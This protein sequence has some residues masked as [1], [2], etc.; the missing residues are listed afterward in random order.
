MQKKYKAYLI[1]LD[2]TIYRG[3]Q[4]IEGASDFISSLNQ[5]KI[6]YLFVTNNSTLTP[7]VV[8][9]KLAAF[10]IETSKKH[11]LTS[12][13]ATASYLKREAPH[14][15]CFVIGETG[16]F[17]ALE[18]AGFDLVEE[19][20]DYVL[21]GLDRDIN[22]KKLTD[23]Q[24]EIRSG[25]QFISTNKDQAIPTSTGFAPGNGALSS[26]LTIST[27][28]DPL[29]IGKPEPIIMNEAL[30][31]LGLNHQDVL[32]IGDNYQTDILAGIR[33]NIDTLLV[34]TGV[35]SYEDYLALDEK[36]S[37]VANNLSEWLSKI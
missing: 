18:Q 9:E 25:A 31:K 36:P 23:A 14:A 8:A 17:Q 6:P 4:V 19:K 12:A 34:L 37:F 1:D 21:M 16:L 2:G 28:K 11:I 29:F 35:T 30:N 32:M 22:Y 20:S 33:S 13:L 5:K 15:R 7:E 24:R 26:V 3:E 27:G 10:G